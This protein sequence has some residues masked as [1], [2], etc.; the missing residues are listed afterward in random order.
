MTSFQLHG[1]KRFAYSTTTITL[2]LP[3]K[4]LHVQLHSYDIKSLDRTYLCFFLKSNTHKKRKVK[5]LNSLHQCALCK[6][7]IIG[8]YLCHASPHPSHT[9]LGPAKRYEQRG[10][11]L[12][13]SDALQRSDQAVRLLQRWHHQPSRCPSHSSPTGFKGKDTR[14][15]VVDTTIVCFVFQR[16]S[17][18]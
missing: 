15:A 11:Q 4:R 13:L 2:L 3:V 14:V 16:N 8:V 17:S 10:D 9:Y 12:L 1:K 18:R 5:T 7:K 6:T